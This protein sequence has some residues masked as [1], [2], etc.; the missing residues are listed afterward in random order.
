M[1]SLV[2]EENASG[3]VAWCVS[4]DGRQG[5]PPLSSF[6][7]ECSYLI[8]G[9]GVGYCGHQRGDT[10]LTGSLLFVHRV[11]KRM[12]SDGPGG[13]RRSSPTAS[14]GAPLNSPC[15][16]GPSSLPHGTC[17]IPRPNE[18]WTWSSAHSRCPKMSSVRGFS[19]FIQMGF[20]SQEE[21]WSH[22]EVSSDEFF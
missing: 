15:Q 21:A 6:R 8:H 1:V 4:T 10:Q 20:S 18:G 5:I 16:L 19:R 13:K 17:G 14:S 12:W 3:S 22:S 11:C 9:M 2:L 7:C